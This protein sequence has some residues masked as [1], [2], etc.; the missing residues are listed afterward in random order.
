MTW[1][2]IYT[3]LLKGIRIPYLGTGTTIAKRKEFDPPQTTVIF[4]KSSATPPY[5][6]NPGIEARLY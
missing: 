2:G 4:A 5:T 3:N 6:A 1:H